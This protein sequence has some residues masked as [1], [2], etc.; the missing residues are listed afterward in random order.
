MRRAFTL[1]ELLVAISIIALL[2]GILLPALVKARDSARSAK[3][4]ANLRGIGQGVMLYYNESDLLPAVLPIGDPFQNQDD[5]D[6]LALL[7]PYVGAP[8]PRREDPGDDNSPWIAQAL[9]TCPADRERPYTS[10]QG[11]SLTVAQNFGASYEYDVGV[12]LVYL[13]GFV[14]PDLERDQMQRLI[15]RAYERRNWPIVSDAWTFHGGAS[16]RNAL[17]FP[18][19]SAS[20][21]RPPP[22]EAYD[23]FEKEMGVDTSGRAGP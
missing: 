9:W 8:K 7:A 6:L 15:T 2:I 1:I 5:P 23:L 17:Y 12:H 10:A 11:R 16:P 18:D 14:R 22:R 13:E 4:L 3:C 19:M 20:E 21:N